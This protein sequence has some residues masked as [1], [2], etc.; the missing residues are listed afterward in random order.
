[1]SKQPKPPTQPSTPSPTER[2][3]SSGRGEASGSK[4]PSKRALGASERREA[5]VAAALEEFTA[6]GFAATRL[7]DVAKRAGVA[8]GTIYLHFKDKEALFQ[9]LVRTALVPLIARLSNPP[10]MGGSVRGMMEGFADMLAHEVV[11]TKRGEIVRLI[12]S[13]G[14]R[15]PELADFYYREVVAHGIAGMRRLVEYGVARGEI[16]NKGLLEFPQ[17]VIAPAILSI[18]WQALFGKI[19]PLDTKAMLHVHLDLIFSERSAP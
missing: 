6:R 1:M 13:E 19:A 2:Q 9:E 4:R 18:V 14:T 17:L 15:F 5:I 8:K 12:I 10:T 7:D 11:G 16:Q 3:R